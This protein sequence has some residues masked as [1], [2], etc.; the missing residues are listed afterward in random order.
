MFLVR[1]G[2]QDREAVVV[3]ASV[4]LLCR[5]YKPL[6]IPVF[7]CVC[8]CVWGRGGVSVCMFGVC[9]GCVSVC[10]HGVCECV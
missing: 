9:L 7:V 4:E 6:A 8:V 5:A 10:V 3:V 2:I 1:V